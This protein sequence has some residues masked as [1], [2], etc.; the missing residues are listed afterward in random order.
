MPEITAAWT[1]T[2]AEFDA[3]AAVSGDD[4][5]IHVDPDFSARTAFGRTVSHGMLIYAK[6]WGLVMAARPETRQLRQEMMFPA[7]CFAGEPVTLRVA[8]D[9][10]GRIEMTARRAADGAELF[11]GAAE[12]A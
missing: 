10:P 11:V 2:Q 8:G 6:L 1:P 7:P 5:P 3:F 12:V 4:N 9:W